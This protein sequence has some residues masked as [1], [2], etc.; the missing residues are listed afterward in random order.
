V[1]S[2]KTIGN[3]PPISSLSG[4]I[5]HG[6]HVLRLWSA[7]LSVCP[8]VAVSIPDR[9][10]DRARVGHEPAIVGVVDHPGLS[11]SNYLL[12]RFA[13]RPAILHRH[14]RADGSSVVTA[15]DQPSRAPARRIPPPA[16]SRNVTEQ[17]LTGPPGPAL[18]RT[19]ATS[20]GARALLSICEDQ[21]ED[22]WALGA[23][24]WC[25]GGNEPANGGC[26]ARFLH[27]SQR[28]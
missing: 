17:V 21:V 13:A 8:R 18:A 12:D 2:A 28:A 14:A 23:A 26:S 15:R 1:I 9:P 24:C 10:P 4:I 3:Q 5:G 11:G 6:H 22:I 16:A 20:V 27:Q 7:G 19:S 25:G